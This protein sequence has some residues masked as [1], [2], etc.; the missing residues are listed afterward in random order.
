LS[1]SSTIPDFVSSSHRELV[2]QPGAAAGAPE[3][4]GDIVIS[5]RQL[6]ILVLEADKDVVDITMSM[7]QEL[8]H[9]ARGETESLAA[10]R[11]FSESPDE[12]DLAILEPVMPDVTG[13]ELAARFRRIRRGFP[14]LLYADGSDASSAERIE[15]AGLGRVVFKPL[16]S[17][18]LGSAIRET[19]RLSA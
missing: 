12:F 11:A 2:K 7:L 18:E 15:A 4:R 3:K 5:R 16:T 8:G 9:Y 17:E 13:L 6:H 14:V 19:L 10:L 1:V